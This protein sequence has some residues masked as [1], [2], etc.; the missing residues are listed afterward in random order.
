MTDVFST[1]KRSEVMRAIRG[2]D[3]KP[4]RIVA[5]WLREERIAFR[6][7]VSRLPGCPDFVL[8]RYRIVVLVHGC[9]WHGHKV[10]RKGRTRPRSR[11]V[12]WRRKIEGNVRRDAR[13][14]RRLRSMGYSVLTIWEC[15]LRNG[16][17]P[18]RFAATMRRAIARQGR[19]RPE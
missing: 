14:T 12:F 1:Q 5:A 13:T 16:R 17:A 15:E 2:A 10:C 11:A 7:C 3:T 4:E 19:S 18:V 6:R 9:F 8:S